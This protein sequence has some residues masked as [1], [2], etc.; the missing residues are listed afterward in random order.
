[1]HIGTQ[2]LGGVDWPQYQALSQ[3]GVTHVSADPPGD[4][5]TWTADVLGD[6]K[7][8]LAELGVSLDIVMLPFGSSAAPLNGAPLV[9]LG[10]PDDRDREIDQICELI[11][12][13][14][15][16]GIGAARYNTAILGHIRTAD[17]LGRGGA[18]LSSF[19]Y[20]KLTAPQAGAGT[21]HPA[22][23]ERQQSAWLE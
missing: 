15:M 14:S 16:A 23:M 2:H 11:R 7:A 13:L 6:F 10:P 3:L 9:F 18:R 5:R 21:R 20:P 22:Q 19:E 1:M 17:R 8:R 4:W 12:D